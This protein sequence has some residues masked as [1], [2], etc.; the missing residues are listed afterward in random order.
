[1][2]EELE[3]IPADAYPVLLQQQING[4]GLGV[5]VLLW[6]SDLIAAFAHRRI[7]EKPPS[8]GVSVLRESIPLDGR[9]LSQSLAL[10]RNFKWKG[11]AMV[12]YKIDGDSGIP[13]LMEINGRFWGSLQLAIDAGVDFPNLLVQLALGANPKPVTTYRTGVR[14]RWEWGDIDHLLAIMLRPSKPISTPPTVPKLQ[15]FGAI[16]DFVRGFNRINRTE[17]FRRDDP[18]PFY[19]ETV[20]WFRRR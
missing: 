6:E 12:E 2:R 19:R 15:R 17:V 11:V 14:S 20:N 7:R 8:G 13:Y 1:L 5:S 3:Q 4:F 18:R 9:L 16:A 10:L